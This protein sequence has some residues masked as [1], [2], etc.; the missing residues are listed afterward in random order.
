[1]ATFIGEIQI[2]GGN[3][4]PGGWALCNGQVLPISDNQALF[5][6]VGTTFGGN[7]TCRSWHCMWAATGPGLSPRVLGQAGGVDQVTLTVPEL[8]AHNHALY[9]N[10]GTPTATNAGNLASAAVYAPDDGSTLVALDGKS[11]DPTVGSSSHANDQPYLVVNF[12]IS[13]VGQ[14]PSFS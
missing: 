4:A 10:T 2:F 7:G 1:M 8:P 12:I 6:L 11:V 13:L 5:S 3:F 14:Y 9:G